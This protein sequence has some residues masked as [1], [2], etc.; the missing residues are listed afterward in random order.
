MDLIKYKIAEPPSPQPSPAGEG[1]R[2]PVPLLLGEKGLGD[3]GLQINC[4]YLLSSFRPS[5]AFELLD[6]ITNLLLHRNLNY[7]LSATY[8]A[9]SFHKMFYEPECPIQMAV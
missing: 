6:Y 1:G 8:N 2:S 9:L 5:D 7:K 3:E 4:T